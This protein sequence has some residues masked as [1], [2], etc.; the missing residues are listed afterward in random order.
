MISTSNNLAA[1]EGLPGLVHRSIHEVGATIS[2]RQSLLGSQQ[3]P[4]H[5]RNSPKHHIIIQGIQYELG[6]PTSGWHPSSY[7]KFI[8]MII[9]DKQF[10]SFIHLVKQGITDK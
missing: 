5:I 6:Y 7:I 8:H 9:T 1:Y 3:L 2:S 4:I 10:T